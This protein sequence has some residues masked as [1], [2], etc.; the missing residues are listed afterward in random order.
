MISPPLMRMQ[1]NASLQLL[2]K[3]AAQRRLEAVNC[4]AL[5]GGIC[6]DGPVV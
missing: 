5:F 1:P 3:A 4:K 2:P 6:R